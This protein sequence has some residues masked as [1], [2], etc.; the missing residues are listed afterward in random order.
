MSKHLDKSVVLEAIGLK[1]TYQQSDSCLD[2]LKGVD[3]RVGEGES[4]SVRGES[5]VGKTTFLYA[6]SALESIQAGKLYWEGQD[7]ACMSEDQLAKYRSRLIGFVFQAYYLVPELNVL[8]NACL[9]AK[10]CGFYTDAL[11][12]RVIELLSRVGLYSK[13]NTM[14]TL[15]SG[16]EKQRVA[17]VRALATNPKIIMADE[18]TGNLDEQTAIVV[19]D[20]LLS[21]CKNLGTSLV[22]VTHNEAFAKKTDREYVLKQGRF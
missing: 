5:G 16:G 14:P 7:T 19:M 3:F 20:M 22:L 10:I 8:E 2:I 11:R 1:K 15:L 13:I 6:L 21:I 4:I 18:P 17:I 9:S 12:M